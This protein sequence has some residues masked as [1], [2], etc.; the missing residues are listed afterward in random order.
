MRV[1]AAFPDN[2]GGALQAEKDVFEN[3]DFES[4]NVGRDGVRSAIGGSVFTD[5][6][7]YGSMGGSIDTAFAT[8]GAGSGE[9]RINEW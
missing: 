5:G 6:R 9:M 8:N 1:P 2:Q 7:V 3:V 4:R